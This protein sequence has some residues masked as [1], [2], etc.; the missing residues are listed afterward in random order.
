MNYSP[1]NLAEWNFNFIHLKNGSSGGKLKQ[2]LNFI[3]IELAY[4]LLTLK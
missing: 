2:N 1:Q 4:S 3:G